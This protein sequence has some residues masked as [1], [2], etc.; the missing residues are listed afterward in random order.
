MSQLSNQLTVGTGTLAG[1][2]FLVAPEHVIPKK[3]P[4]VG[5]FRFQLF[6]ACRCTTG[7]IFRRGSVSINPTLFGRFDPPE[8]R[9]NGF[10][11]CL[12]ARLS[13]TAGF[14]HAF[15]DAK[16]FWMPGGPH[17]GWIRID[18]TSTVEGDRIELTHFSGPSVLL[19][20]LVHRQPSITLCRL[21]LFLLEHDL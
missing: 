5:S 2:Q 17:P 6:Q 12:D 3:Q 10:H 4:Q 7:T 19:F 14:H 16:V 13:I 21:G 11:A 15:T 9:I 8:M 1:L 18:F 20:N